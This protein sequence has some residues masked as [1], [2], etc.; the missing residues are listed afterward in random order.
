MSPED[1]V[2]QGRVR[3]IFH[4]TVQVTPEIYRLR[5]LVTDC[6]IQLHCEEEVVQSDEMISRMTH[7]YA[8]RASLKM[9]HNDLDFVQ[10]GMVTKTDKIMREH[11]VTTGGPLYKEGCFNKHITKTA[12]LCMVCGVAQVTRFS[13]APVCFVDDD[14]PHESKLQFVENT[15]ELKKM[16]MCA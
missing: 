13:L 8:I 1:I 4:H 15:A 12:G 6:A 10:I 2:R 9:P 16:E 5:N 7:E 11:L 14:G 3:E